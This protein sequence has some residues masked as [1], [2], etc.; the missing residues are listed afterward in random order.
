LPRRCAIRIRAADPAFPLPAP[1]HD[2]AQ[3]GKGIGDISLTGRYWVFDTQTHDTWNIAAGGG[4]E[5]CATK[6]RA[7]VGTCIE[8]C[9]P[10]PPPTCEDRCRHF[11]EDRLAEC[12]AAG[13]SEEECTAEARAAHARCVTLHCTPPPGCE[14]RC[15][16]RAANAERACVALGGDAER[17][18]G[19]ARR[20]DARCTAKFCDGPPPP[21][22]CALAC[23]LRAHQ[24]LARAQ[25][26]THA[27]RSSRR[28]YIR[29]VRHACSDAE[30]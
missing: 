24:L 30:P 25:D 28:A 12:R 9:T 10:E 1:R 7:A 20:V 29:C 2:I 3:N 27:C 26:E 16:V 11:A 15:A 5:E 21:E 6:A 18:A 14:D 13:G 4:V 19:F 23:E 17:C 22:P 8:D